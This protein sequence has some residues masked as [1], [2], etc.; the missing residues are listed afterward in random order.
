MAAR[1]EVLRGVL[2]LGG[3]AAAHVT[4]RQA[5]P[6]FHPPITARQA[7]FA[8]LGSWRHWSDLVNV[9]AS[10]FGHGVPRFAKD[11]STERR[12]LKEG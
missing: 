1:L 12:P 11:L 4:A 10:L 2:V 8:A 3:I 9:G 7:F 6:Q 5:R